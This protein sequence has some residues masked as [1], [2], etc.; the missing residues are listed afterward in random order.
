MFRGEVEVG[1]G[2]LGALDGVVASL[3]HQHHAAVV[4]VAAVNREPRGQAGAGLDAKVEVVLVEVLPAAAGR[5][6]VEHALRRQ[7]CLAHQGGQRPLDAFI[8]HVSH[9]QQADGSVH[10]L[11]W[12]H[13]ARITRQRVCNVG[14]HR[15]LQPSFRE[16]RHRTIRRG[17]H[18]CVSD[19][20]NLRATAGHA[21]RRSRHA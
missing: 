1:V 17:G 15:R 13:H 14:R 4:L 6:E 2:R 12:V 18:E 3:R 7:R 11:V 5:L 20:I 8:K 19:F 16:P 21:R 10:M 9:G